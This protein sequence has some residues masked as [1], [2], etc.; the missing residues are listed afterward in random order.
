MI[1]RA[2]RLN[3]KFKTEILFKV[4]DAISFKL[5]DESIDGIIFGFNGLM[6]IPIRKN[7][8]KVM[9]E[10]NRLLKLTVYFVFTTHDRTMPKWKKFW[11]LE[12]KKWKR[13]SRTQNF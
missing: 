13:E 1:K 10:V 8:Q 5:S 4:E 2:K 11:T 7:R 9:L 3:R 6:Q 12:K